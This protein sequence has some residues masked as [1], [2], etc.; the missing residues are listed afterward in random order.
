M[1]TSVQTGEF[2]H[3]SILNLLHPPERIHGIQIQDISDAGVQI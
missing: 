1:N 3:P 2:K